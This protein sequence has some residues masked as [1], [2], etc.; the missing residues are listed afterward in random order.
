M[1]CC[2]RQLYN[3]TII[4]YHITSLAFNHYTDPDIYPPLNIK[5]INIYIYILY[6]HPR[7]PADGEKAIILHIEVK[8]AEP[9]ENCSVTIVVWRASTQGSCDISVENTTDSY[10]TIMQDG[11]E[12]DKELSDRNLFQVCLCLCLCPSLGLGLKEEV[13][14]G[15]SFSNSILVQCVLFF[16]IFCGVLY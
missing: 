2:I 3:T 14:V 5:H 4:L 8:I 1:E 10:F 15:R 11:I 16:F 6:L 9:G 13:K 7:A 12:L